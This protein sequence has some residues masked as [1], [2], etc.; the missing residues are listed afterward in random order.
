MYDL[1][2]KQNYVVSVTSPL[3]LEFGNP[4]EVKKLSLNY[5]KFINYAS[6]KVLVSHHYGDPKKVTFS[7]CPHLA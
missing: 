7:K 6:T 3:F 5:T 2:L 1:S 4:L